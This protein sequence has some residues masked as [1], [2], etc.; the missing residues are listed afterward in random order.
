MPSLCVD[1][2]MKTL[3]P[4]LEGAHPVS[5]GAMMVQV[6]VHRDLVEHSYHRQ[7]E[8]TMFCFPLRAHDA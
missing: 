7:H 5:R 3:R 8:S 2:L 1:W 6:Q 4:Q